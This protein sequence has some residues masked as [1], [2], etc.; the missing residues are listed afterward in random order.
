VK[1]L[2]SDYAVNWRWRVVAPYVCGRVLDIGCGFTHLP[3]RL[4]ADQAYVGVDVVAKAV[5]FGQARYPQHTFYQCDVNCA[6]LPLEGQQFDTILMMAVLEHL[7]APREALRAV[8]LH[9]APKGNLLLTTPSPLGDW[10]HRMG[11]RVKLFYPEHV[12]KHVKIFG[13][14]ALHEWLTDCG[15]E[16]LAFHYFE[17]GIN[18]LVVCC[19]QPDDRAAVHAEMSV[20]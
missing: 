9:L 6:P 4:A 2:L 13:K 10:V 3:D 18:Q 7:S 1:P 15:Y 5:S 11:S 17:G 14:R 12:V 19:G 16:V 20:A 8:R